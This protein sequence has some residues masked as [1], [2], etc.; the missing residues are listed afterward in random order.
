MFRHSTLVLLLWKSVNVVTAVEYI[1]C[2]GSQ[3][4]PCNIPCQGVLQPELWISLRRETE[5]PEQDWFGCQCQRDLKG[6][7]TPYVPF[8]SSDS[9]NVIASISDGGGGYHPGS[10]SEARTQNQNAIAHVS[11]S[12]GDGLYCYIKAW[13]EV[14]FHE[15]NVFALW[16]NLECALTDDSEMRQYMDN[17]EYIKYPPEKSLSGPV[18]VVQS[19]SDTWVVVA[20]GLDGFA[21]HF[22]DFEYDSA[23][24]VFTS[25]WFKH[26]CGADVG[27]YNAGKGTC[28]PPTR[29]P[30][31]L[32]GPNP[33]TP[34]PTFPT[35]LP[36]NPTKPIEP[37]EPIFPFSSAPV[38]RFVVLLHVGLAFMMALFLIV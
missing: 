20:T 27:D 29:A 25:T 2:Q 16:G 38:G 7:K 24:T 4:Y 6:D 36:P 21:T 22:S 28:F 18:K 13:S 30:N 26:D 17:R 33:F 3:V 9:A 1:P 15:N 8:V 10:F 31:P 34:A 23:T 35:P 11:C 12:K 19:S 5:F 37:T 14:A 32:F